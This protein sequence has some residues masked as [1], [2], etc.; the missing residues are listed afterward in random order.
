MAN[1]KNILWLMALLLCFGIGVRAGNVVSL[2]SVSGAPGTEV[3][4]SVSLENTDAVSTVQ[5]SI[6]LDENLSLVGNSAVASDRLSDHSVTV[7]VKDGVLNIVVYS[8]NMTAISGNSGEVVT[9]R[10]L[11]GDT[12]K[13]IALTPSRLLLVGPDSQEKT[14]TTV[15]GSVSIRCAKAQYGS[16]TVDFGSVPIRSIYTQTVSISNVGNEPLT[17]TEINFSDATFSTTTTLPLTVNAGQS[18]NLNVTYAPTERGNVEEQ[19]QVVCNSISKLNTIQLTAQPFAVNE[20]HVGD[21]SGISDET[22]SIPLSMNNMDDIIGF[23]LEFNLPEALEYVDGSFELS[24]RKDDH[25]A[26]VTLQGRKLTI[27]A[28]STT[29]KAFKGNDGVLGCF[30]VKLVGRYGVTLKPTTDILSAV[31]G[32]EIMNVMSADYAGQVTI[33]SPRISASS[34]LAF[35]DQP[36]TEAVEQTYTIRNYGS[37]PLTVSRILFNDERFSVKETLPLVINTSGSSTITIVNNDKTSG[38]FSGTMQIYS[39]DPDQRLLTA[40]ITGRV[41]V[42]NHLSFS[43]DDVFLG[44]DVG[45]TVE[46]DNYDAISGVQFDITSTDEYTID[47]TKVEIGARAEGMDL[48]IQQVDERTL[49][50]VGYMMGG[51]IASGSGKLMTIYLTP[52]AD[53]AEGTHRLTISNMLLGDD[54][55][56]NKYEGPASQSVSF[57]SKPFLLGDANGDKV[58]DVNDV[59]MTVDRILEKDTEG[60]VFDAADVNGDKV[61]NVNDVVGVVDIILWGRPG[62][63]R[64][65]SMLFDAEELNNDYLNL[66]L[67]DDQTASLCLQNQGHYVAAQFDLHLSDGQQLKNIRLN[68]SR[69]NGH[70]LSY[71]HVGDNVYR[72]VIVSLGNRSFRNQTGE[73]VTIQASNSGNIEID[74][75]EFATNSQASK[76]FAP[77]STTIT[78]IE[79]I[80]GNRAVDIYTI[81][82]QLVRKQ[83]G[84]TDGLKRGIY[85]INNR[86]VLVK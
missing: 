46:M 62:L 6:P 23:Q 42:P 20:L 47:V 34:A 77:L 84:S 25:Q 17:V 82:G 13:D 9:F 22:V 48:T 50:L 33:Q 81:G 16:M 74:N 60:F 29:G 52:T 7:G 76:K 73:L 28:V 49:R 68:S 67:N 55:L 64:T 71:E 11:V 65:R 83:A 3:S 54:D 31:I 32:G 21:V 57:E 41:F 75:I 4:V 14:G 27:V 15:A 72:V 56:I 69:G 36:I 79:T 1:K 80:T 86:K 45:L 12:P 30:S 61:I 58:V 85:I 26:T 59:V 40:N 43:A 70:L 53:L 10:L 78:S 24:D 2:S 18:A 63:S 44:D 39:N 5:L 37:A 51:N 66:I 19:M 38:S 8:Q 35:G